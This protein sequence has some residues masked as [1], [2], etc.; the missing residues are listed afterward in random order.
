MSQH[1]KILDVTVIETISWSIL[2]LGGR[3]DSEI[4]QGPSGCCVS[5]HIL[6]RDQVAIKTL[7]NTIYKFQGS[8]QVP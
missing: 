3:D 7:K 1:V 5:V 8:R 4:P 2:G 6:I